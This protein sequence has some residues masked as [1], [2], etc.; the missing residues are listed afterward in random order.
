MEV[1]IVSFIVIA[2]ILNFYLLIVRPRQLIWGSTKE[3]INNIYIGEQKIIYAK[4]KL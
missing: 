4:I 2:I 3:E 1:F